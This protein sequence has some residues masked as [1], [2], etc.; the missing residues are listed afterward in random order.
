MTSRQDLNAIGAFQFENLIRN[1]IPF[2]LLNLGADLDG[3]FPPFHQSH[4]ERQTQKT[5]SSEAL[6]TLRQSALPA[7]QAVLLICPTGSECPLVAARLEEAGYSN[8]YWI[9]GGIEALRRDL[10]GA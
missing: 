4:L 3:L 8:V 5:S 1:R 7:E 6:M 2:V 9:Q 10:E